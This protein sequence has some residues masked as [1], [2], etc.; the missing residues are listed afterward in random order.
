MMRLDPLAELR[1]APHAT[2]YMQALRKR[3]ESGQHDHEFHISNALR[4]VN[5]DGSFE[6]LQRLDQLLVAYKTK[7][8]ALPL[9]DALEPEKINTILVIASYLGAFIAQKT[10][11][12]E[13][14]LSYAELQQ[15]T[16]ELKDMP[17]GLGNTVNLDHDGNLIFIILQVQ[18]HFAENQFARSISQ[19]IENLLLNRVILRAGQTQQYAEEMHAIQ[20]IYQKKYDLFCRTSFQN[21]VD[22][23]QLDYSLASLER[24]DEL[25]REIRQN[26][27]VSPQ[28]FLSEQSHYYFL[29][30]LA[31]YIGRVI[32]QHAGT[33][34]RWFDHEQVS[35]MLGENIEA[36]ISTIH[37]A[38]VSQNLL[39]SMGH[40]TA[41]L[42][43][44]I[45]QTTSTAYAQ[46][47]IHLL[48]QQNIGRCYAIKP[49]YNN[50]VKN[51]PLYLALHQAGLLLG[52]VLQH[53]HGVWPRHDDS[54]SLN[55]CSLPPGSTFFSHIGDFEHSLNEFNQ[56]FAGYP[57][58]V[59]AYEMYCCLPHLRVD[60]IAIEVKTFQAPQI[61]ITLH[62]PFFQ[63][64][65][66]RGFC[67][68]QPYFTLKDSASDGYLAEILAT[69]DAFFT[70]IHGFEAPIPE[71]RRVWDQHYHPARYPYP[72]GFLK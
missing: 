22:A 7:V 53:I 47:F 38:Q 44:P 46:K 58:N 48:Q 56:N 52:Y 67:I 30:F 54:E 35:R 59:L 68:L 24:L 13:K 28:Q 5:F 8:G 10:P 49:S 66:Y 36:E 62:I 70:G 64:F 1:A 33:S 40:I 63:N 16:D 43:E 72:E 61:A 37:V 55:P 14:W 15:A 20:N 65:D 50:Q 26:Y 34:L 21:L 9:S 6:S 2:H 31:G 32:A 39:F 41:F 29:L 42:F 57:Y 18:Q 45:I 11:C 4:T 3:F 19:N 25:M 60:A 17:E 71:T 12:E 69:M 27:L 23:S 51:S